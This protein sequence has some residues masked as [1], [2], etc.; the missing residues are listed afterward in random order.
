MVLAWCALLNSLSKMYYKVT[1]II[2]P[3]H[4]LLQEFN[5]VMLPAIAIKGTAADSA[6]V[7]YKLTTRKKVIVSS[8][9]FFY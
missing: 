3:H 5:M 2:L 4:I 6:A 1:K 7:L 8:K 9:P